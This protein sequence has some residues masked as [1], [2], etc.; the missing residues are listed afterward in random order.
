M[1]V[2]VLALVLLVGIFGGVGWWVYNTYIVTSS[3]G[4]TNTIQKNNDQTSV[5]KVQT[6]NGQDV[7]NVSDQLLF[8]SEA[9]SDAD[10]LSDTRE[11][12]IGTDP[13][14]WDTDGDGLSDYN[15]V[16]VWKTDPHNIDTDGDG[17]KDGQEV[18]NGYNPAGPGKIFQPPS[19]TS[20]V[21]Q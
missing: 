11:T 10:G 2:I 16:V 9:D 15:E 4:R 5:D 7:N 6:S 3:I 14:N 13:R 17:F 20:A 19:T 18:T 12:Q 1:I 8:G 21:V